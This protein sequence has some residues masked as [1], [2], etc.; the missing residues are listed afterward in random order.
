[1]VEV[2]NIFADIASSVNQEQFLTL[3]ENGTIKVERIVSHT[4]E[5]PEQFWYDQPETEW[6]MVV[7]GAAT[8]E[9]SGGKLVEMKEG[10]H[11]TIPSHVKHRVHHTSPQTI[12]LAVHVKG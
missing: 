8:L 6:V 10:D 11:V 4:Y 7:R 9:F 12:W 5:S 1:M 2:K 3:F